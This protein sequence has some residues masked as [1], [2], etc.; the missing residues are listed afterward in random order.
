MFNRLR[1][2]LCLLSVIGAALIAVACSPSTSAADVENAKSAGQP[3]I[4]RLADYK[5]AHGRYPDTFQEAG[6]TPAI[7]D[8]G[9][10]EYERHVSEDD[11]YFIVRVGDYGRNGFVLF[12]NSDATPQGWEIEE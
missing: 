1:K 5:S 2:C 3:I 7:T 6:I 12:W 11:E 10:F 9:A 8:F 4:Q